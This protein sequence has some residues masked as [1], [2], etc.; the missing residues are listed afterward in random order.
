MREGMR[1]KIVGTGR[2]KAR[3]FFGTLVKRFKADGESWALLRD[4]K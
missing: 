1:Y 3:A 2:S 4:V